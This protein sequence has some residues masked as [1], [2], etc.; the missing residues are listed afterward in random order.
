MGYQEILGTRSLS[1]L[2]M[3]F[4]DVIDRVEQVLVFVGWQVERRGDDL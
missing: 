4:R 2:R 3:F 1:S